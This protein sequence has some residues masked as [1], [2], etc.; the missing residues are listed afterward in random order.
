MGR[1]PRRITHELARDTGGRCLAIRYRLSPQNPFPTAL[2]DGLAAYLYLLY[3]PAG[4]LHA[5]VTTSDI[6]FTG[7]SAGG[8]LAI[9]LV[10]LILE[11]IREGSKNAPGRLTWDGQ[12]R[13][14]PV[15]A[16]V[17][18]LSPYNDLTRALDSEST[19]NT[20]LYPREAR[21]LR[22]SI[23]VKFGL[24]IHLDIMF[25]QMTMLS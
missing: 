25:M 13:D 19:Y 8:N 1:E 12:E 18:I 24:V 23:L 16:G 17:S 4:S 20:T 9:A 3:L 21:L 2:I 22:L 15:P 6:C 7:D 5:P 11:I 14:L 10:Q